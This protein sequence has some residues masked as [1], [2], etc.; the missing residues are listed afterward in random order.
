[1]KRALLSTIVSCFFVACAAQQQLTTASIEKA[2]LARERDDL[3]R[4]RRDLQVEVRMLRQ[5]L[6]SKN[7]QIMRSRGETTS[8]QTALTGCEARRGDAQIACDNMLQEVRTN[9]DTMAAQCE[10]ARAQAV[11]EG[12][13][14]MLQS[15]EVV[16]TPSVVKGW[17]IDDHFYTFQVRVDG[18]VA[19][20]TKIETKGEETM[21][22]RALSTITEV[23]GAIA[24][25]R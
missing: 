23:A 16:G 12:Q 10:T 2:N 6:A 22:A 17:L 21:F 3:L 11:M 18:K 5:E 15:I 8:C 13:L 9:C 7:D 14:R 25:H 24:L 20:L 19:I 4:E 1:M